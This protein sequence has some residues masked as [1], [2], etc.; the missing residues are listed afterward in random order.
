MSKPRA[1]TAAASIAILLAGSVAAAPTAMAAAA[2]GWPEGAPGGFVSWGACANDGDQYCVES[3]T[4]N[5]SGALA[6]V[7]ILEGTPTINPESINFIVMSEY[8]LRT[9]EQEPLDLTKLDD[10][11]RIK[12]RVGDWFVPNYTTAYARDFT[13]DVTQDESGNRTLTIVGKPMHAFWDRDAES[14]CTLGSCGGDVV[15]TQEVTSFSGNVQNMSTWGQE[16]IDQFGG[17]YIAT[18]AQTFSPTVSFSAGP[19]VEGGD[20][21]DHWQFQVANPHFQTDGTTPAAGDFEAFVPGNYYASI[22]REPTDTLFAASRLDGSDLSPLTGSTTVMNDGAKLTIADLHYSEPTLMVRN[23]ARPVVAPGAVRQL[24]STGSGA[25]NRVVTWSEPASNG[26]AAIN[27]YRVAVVRTYVV[28]VRKKV[29]KTWKYVN[30]TRTA[31]V[32]NKIQT[33]RSLAFKP[34]TGSYRASVAARNAGNKFGPATAITIK[35]K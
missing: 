10:V 33:S 34:D 35:G 7:S 16:A 15:A 25:A 13:M 9:P 29:K 18:N 30:Q 31:T 3:A 5:G 24:R 2:N 8:Q 22:G 23:V 20:P 17:M 27:G 6:Q 14:P 12:I 1:I 32:M 19:M 28:K 4:V 21:V 26:Y 11:V